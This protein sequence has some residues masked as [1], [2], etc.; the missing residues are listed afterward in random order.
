MGA[1]KRPRRI[2]R[3]PP[4]RDQLT[5]KGVRKPM[6]EL[7]RLRRSLEHRTE[8]QLAEAR[9]KA[10]AKLE[11]IRRRFDRGGDGPPF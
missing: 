4:P 2:R 9:A 8:E 10:H 6:H 7:D 1:R 3:L 5:L 11:A